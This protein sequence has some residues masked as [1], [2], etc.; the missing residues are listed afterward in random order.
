MLL[1]PNYTSIESIHTVHFCL[2][3]HNI[4]LKISERQDV[5]DEGTK[6]GTLQTLLFR[7]GV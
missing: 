7:K 5:M 1:L 4:L 3:V 6:R 2:D